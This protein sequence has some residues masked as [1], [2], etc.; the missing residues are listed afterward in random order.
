MRRPR[1][2]VGARQIALNRELASATSAEAVLRLWE[3]QGHEFNVINVSTALHRLAKRAH[4]RERWALARDP[5]VRGLC[6]EATGRIRNFK[7]QQL[8]SAV[9]AS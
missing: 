2:P 8:A 7:P 5:C 4:A 6:A 9:W 1:D 3:H